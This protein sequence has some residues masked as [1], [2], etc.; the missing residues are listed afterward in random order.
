MARLIIAG[1]SSG[2]GKTTI[3]V[4]LIAALRVRGLS[5]QPFK[6]GPDYI[7]PSYHALAAGRPCRNLDSWMVPPDRVLAS[8]RRAARDVD[9]AVVEGVMGLYDGFG[10]DDEAGSTAAASKLLDA[11][12]I[13]VIDASKM[14]RSAGAIALGYRRFDPDLNLAGFIVNYVGGDGHGR[15]VASAIERA[16]GLPVF[17][18]LPQDQRL[19]IPERY[20]GLVPTREPGRW[21]DFIHAAEET[22]ARHLDLDRILSIARQAPPLAEADSPEICDCPTT[23]VKGEHPV[24][25]VARDEAFHFTYPENLELLEA[26]G[27]EIAFF[28]PLRDDQLPSRTAGVILSGGFPELYAT[29]LSGNISLHTALRDAHAMRM[30]IYAECGG[31]MYLTEA[32][33]DDQ[34]RQHLMAGLLPGRSAMSGRL[35]LGYRLGRAAHDSWLFKAGETIRGHE[36]HYSSWIDRP[37]GLPAALELADRDGVDPDRSEGAYERNLWASYVHLHFDG[38]PELAGR[39]VAAC[40]NWRSSLTAVGE[41]RQ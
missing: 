5:V 4:G 30:P 6:V 27:A 21:T 1:M 8:F 35:T 11:P 33:V 14:A 13:L 25:A 2:V 20:L 3:T 26:A 41:S 32:I 15:G 22:V 7:D 9:V 19:A 10:Y 18:W 23:H 16:T 36:F 38:H 34:G 17:G 39:F 31:L 37:A 12:V 28:S 24:I 29:D 40:R